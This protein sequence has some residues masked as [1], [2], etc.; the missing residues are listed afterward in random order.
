HDY[1][2]TIPGRGYRFVAPVR[3]LDSGDNSRAGVA[4]DVPPVRLGRRQAL[5][6]AGVLAALIVVFGRGRYSNVSHAQPFLRFSAGTNFAGV[7]GQPAI[8]PDG[9]AVSFVSDRGGQ[10]DIWV[11]LLSG[12]SLVRITNDANIESRPRW[13]PD[14]TKLLYA[15]LNDSGLWDSW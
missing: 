14:G 6:G 9:R 11:G 15:R 7:E 1:I 3:E 5:L 13:S 2:V 8:S 12:G 4:E 10:Y